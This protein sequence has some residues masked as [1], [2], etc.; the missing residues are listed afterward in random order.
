VDEVEK[1]L[2]TVEAWGSI[3]VCGVAEGSNWGSSRCNAWSRR[4]LIS[5]TVGVGSQDCWS[6]NIEEGS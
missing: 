6:V 3:Q 5:G 4:S 2:L 1:P